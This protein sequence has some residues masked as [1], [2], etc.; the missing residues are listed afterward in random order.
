MHVKYFFDEQTIL[1][2]ILPWQNYW[3]CVH[4]SIAS[5]RESEQYELEVYIRLLQFT[6]GGALV[7]V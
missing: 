3:T 7:I 4:L 1:L 5:C 6:K 2:I